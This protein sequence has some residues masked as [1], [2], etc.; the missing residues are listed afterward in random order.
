MASHRRHKE[1]VHRSLGRLEE[2]GSLGRVESA[3][4]SSDR[5]LVMERRAE[6]EEPLDG[7]AQRQPERGSDAAV[8][9]SGR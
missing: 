4:S 6:A 2:I 5:E 3:S 8:V 9:R 7:L 1:P